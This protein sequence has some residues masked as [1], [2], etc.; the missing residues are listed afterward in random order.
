VRFEHDSLAGGTIEPEDFHQSLYH[1]IH[2]INF[3]IMKKYFEAWDVSNASLMVCFGF[4]GRVS[5]HYNFVIW[6]NAAGLA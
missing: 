4:Y 2:S 1:M 5:F 6:K 3:I